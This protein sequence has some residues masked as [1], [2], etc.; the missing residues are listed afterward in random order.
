MFQQKN[1]GKPGDPLNSD[2]ECGS[3]P[4][5]RDGAILPLI[6][7]CLTVI[8]AFVAFAIDLGR[9]C[10]TRQQMQHA[11]DSAALAAV[12][13]L[14]AAFGDF[15]TSGNANPEQLAKNMAVAV[16]AA[17]QMG[18][19]S[20]VYLDAT[21]DI[22]LGQHSI[23]PDTGQ[24]T[25]TWGTP[26]YNV[27][28]VTVHRDGPLGQRDGALP[29]LFAPILGKTQGNL[30]VTSRAAFIPGERFRKDENSR[31]NIMVLPVA[32]QEDSWNSAIIASSPDRLS[33]NPDTNSVERGGDNAVEFDIYNSLDKRLAPG[34][35]GTGGFGSFS[36][37]T[38][39]LIRQIESGL[40][41]DDLQA[42]GGTL[43]VDEEPIVIEASPGNLSG[44][45]DAVA[46]IV[47]ELR[48]IPLFESIT[49]S[50][51]DT[52]YIVTGF[53]GIRIM[54]VNFKG[55]EKYIRV[56]AAA[57]SFDGILPGGSTTTETS[58]ILSPGFLLP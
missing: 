52:S 18:G 5:T 13:Q 37:S 24:V 44:I 9:I 19:Q 8:F 40:N 39:D 7:I 27:V 30:L 6:A 46:T 42:F 57:V 4:R 21:R 22:R 53:G 23:D 12:N 35:F 49:G 38:K 14:I 58:T 10:V 47:G 55:K 41:Y 33:W 48:V 1:L 3:P 26:P 50:G 2:A 17:N 51:G 16:A 36:N 56:Q 28:E 20:G 43:S 31:G 29:L 45:E 25:T 11:A 15:G 34:Q 32:M 54:E